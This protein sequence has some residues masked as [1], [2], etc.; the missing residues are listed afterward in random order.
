M[1]YIA[2]VLLA[3]CAAQSHG[4]DQ[5]L[6]DQRPY[7]VHVPLRYDAT[8]KI[9]VVLDLHGYG[10]SASQ[11]AAYLRLDDVADREMFIVARPEGTKDNAGNRF[12][13]ATD[14]CCDFTG[15]RVDDVAYIGAVLDDLERKYTIDKRR[16]YVV[17][18]SNGAFMAYRLACDLAPR[19]AGVVAV[20]GATWNDFSRCKPGDKVS[21]LAIAGDADPLVHISGGAIDDAT[22]ALIKEA[23][24]KLPTPFIPIKR[25]YPSAEVTVATWAKLDGCTGELAATGELDLDTKLDGNETTRR[26]YTCEG[27]AVE[28]W[29]VRGGGHMPAFGAAFGDEIY[30][31]LKAHP[32]DSASP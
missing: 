10:D 30:S 12:W 13:D 4:S 32:K 31:F 9:P 11:E 16:V 7:D 5:G 26:A 17:G 1:K 25:Q 21:L 27:A 29:T 18:H 23:G 14:A 28:L 6:L 24:I 15:S 3:A 19:I 22:L 8:R 2:L 20:S